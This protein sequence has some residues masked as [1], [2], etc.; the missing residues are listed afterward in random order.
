MLIPPGTE[1]YE[2]MIIGGFRAGDMEVNICREKKL[3][4]MRASSADETVKL[5]PHRQMSLEQALGSLQVTMRESGACAPSKGLP[6]PTRANS[7]GSFSGGVLNDR[8]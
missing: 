7:A 3:T 1:V 5:T 6:R 8:C 2:G 4:N